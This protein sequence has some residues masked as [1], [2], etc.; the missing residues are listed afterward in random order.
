VRHGLALDWPEYS[1]G[2]YDGSEREAEQAGRGIWPG[3]EPWLNRVCIR[4]DGRPTGCSAMLML[5][6][7]KPAARSDFGAWVWPVGQNQINR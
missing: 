1:K 6:L 5:I 4:A 2:K 3:S 7:E